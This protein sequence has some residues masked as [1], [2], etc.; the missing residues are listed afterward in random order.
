MINFGILTL[1]QV[2][3]SGRKKLKENLMSSSG[4]IVN[5]STTVLVRINPEIHA[6]H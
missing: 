4:R 2:K 6:E 3:K 1:D 5:M